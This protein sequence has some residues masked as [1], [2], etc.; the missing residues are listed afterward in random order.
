[1]VPVEVLVG[2]LD[3]TDGGVE[4]PS[5][6]ASGQEDAHV[7]R[8]ADREGVEGQVV[9]VAAVLDYLDDSRDKEERADCLDEEGFGG[10]VLL[11]VEEIGVAGLEEGGVGEGDGIP[12]SIHRQR[13]LQPYQAD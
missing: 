4:A 10:D 2:H 8:G 12:L 3:E 5:R 11:G 6:D 1:M 9:G 13:S 7:K